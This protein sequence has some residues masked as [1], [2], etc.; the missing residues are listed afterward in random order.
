MNKIK[1]A[2]KEIEASTKVLEKMMMDRIK[3]NNG[4]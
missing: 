4:Q 3:K 2:I 1:K